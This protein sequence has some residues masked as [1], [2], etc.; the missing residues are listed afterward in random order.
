MRRTQAPTGPLLARL[1]H[2]TSACNASVAYARAPGAARAAFDVVDLLG[3]P[4]HAQ[5]RCG[6]VPADAATRAAHLADLLAALGLDPAAGGEP[7]DAWT[8]YD[9]KYDHADDPEV[10]DF[11]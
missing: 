4:D 10:N 3:G 2:V 11:S 1:E 5:H 8:G 7:P 6:R 9:W